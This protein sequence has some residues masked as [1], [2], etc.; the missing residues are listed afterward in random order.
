MGILILILKIIG[1][2]LALILAIVCIIIF[3]SINLKVTFNNKEEACYFVKIRYILGAFTYT[4]DSKKNIN[5]IKIFGIKLKNKDKNI[6]V[7]EK[8]DTKEDINIKQEYEIASVDLDIKKDEY[9]KE[10]YTKKTKLKDKLENIKVKI[11]NIIEKIKF[12][13][14]YPNKKEIINASI[15][16]I[17]KL[18]KAI[19]FKKIKINVD[20]GLDDP[21]KT[22]NICGIISSI[23]PF[24]P[25]KYI[26]NINIMPNFN[27]EIFLADLEIKFSTSLFKI[28][29]PIIIFVLKKPIRKIIFS[30]GE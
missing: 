26:K 4:L 6:K 16:L 24:M 28:L 30:K 2:I 7:E 5:T 25:K 11:N 15:V 19:K 17:K 3:S 20:Y 18:L 13:I 1:V 14:N 27:K 29:L 21:F 22:G 9:K 10:D 8:E 12:I 23:I